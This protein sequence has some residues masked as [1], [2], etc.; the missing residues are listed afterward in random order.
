MNKYL[1][2][3]KALW[4]E[5]LQYHPVTTDLEEAQWQRGVSYCS[6]LAG[7]NLALEPYEIQILAREEL[8]T[9]KNTFRII[10]F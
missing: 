4:E 6:L 9:V 2:T 5:L 3:K 7:L 1:D 10:H 8:P